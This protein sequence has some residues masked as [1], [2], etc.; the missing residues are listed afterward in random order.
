MPRVLIVD[1]DRQVCGFAKSALARHGLSV[2][3][4]ANADEARRAL[5]EEQPFDLLLCEVDF[6]GQEPFALARELKHDAR[7]QAAQL[8]LLTRRQGIDDKVSAYELGA[9]LLIHKP[10]F[11]SEFV[12]RLRRLLRKQ[13]QPRQNFAGELA[14]G[15]LHDVVKAALE[16]GR[17]GTIEITTSLGQEGAL[18]FESGRIRSA[19]FRSDADSQALAALLAQ[20]HGS[21]RIRY[22]S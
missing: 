7:C 14:P 21:F 2:R 22:E 1:A 9:A 12:T 18:C 4:A 8:V 13:G 11:L 19:E 5:E 20:N 17:C 3:L 10:V 15:V 6:E 16:S